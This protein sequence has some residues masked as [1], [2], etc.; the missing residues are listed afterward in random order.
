MRIGGIHG[1]FPAARHFGTGPHWQQV[2]VGGRSSGMDVPGGRSGRSRHFHHTRHCPGNS[3]PLFCFFTQ[4]R[5]HPRSLN[6]SLTLRHCI[7][8]TSGRHR[9]TL[10]RQP[11]RQACSDLW[12]SSDEIG[13]VL[14]LKDVGK[15]I[16]Q[17]RELG[18]GLCVMASFHQIDE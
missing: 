9:I 14:L 2:A 6:Q 15:N 10:N 8:S 1:R 7:N 11:P 5:L 17:K 16:S 12:Q 18:H 3:F 4:K 13:A